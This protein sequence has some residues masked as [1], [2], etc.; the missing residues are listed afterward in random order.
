MYKGLN[1]GFSTALSESKPIS[2]IDPILTWINADDIFAQHA[3][4]TAIEYFEKNSTCKWLTGTSAIMNES[5][6]LAGIRQSPAGFSQK[7]LF[8]GQHDGRRLPFVQQEGTFFKESLWSLV[9]GLSDKFSLAGDWDLWRRFAAHN[10]LIKLNCVLAVHRR[11]DGQLSENVKKYYS[12]VDKASKLSP[13][14][15]A[16][17]ENGWSSTYDVLKRCWENVEV[18]SKDLRYQANAFLRDTPKWEP[19][20]FRLTNLPAWV[21][22]ISGLNGVEN[23]GR[24][25]DA[26]LSPTV[27]IVSNVKLP[28]K[29]TLKMR[30][31]A[32]SPSKNS[33]AM[34]CV[35]DEFFE[36]DVKDEFSDIEVKIKRNQEGNSIDIRPK[37][38]ISPASLGWSS[39]DRLLALGFEVLSIEI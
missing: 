2:R 23:F 12:E 18:S 17:S 15:K 24:W 28:E 9:G 16:P 39:D 3:F 10:E 22:S 13:P 4:T 37:S 8:I 33:P 35:G 14:L 6:I 36:V 19:I 21:E 38:A 34:I 7:A 26:L 11:H 30:V 29:F 31:R 20:D 5:G 27:R 32:L 25:S 1:R